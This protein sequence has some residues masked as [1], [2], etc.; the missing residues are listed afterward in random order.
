MWHLCQKCM[1]YAEAIYSDKMSCE[2]FLCWN[3]G[4]NNEC[5]LLFYVWHVYSNRWFTLLLLSHHWSLNRH[6]M[7]KWWLFFDDSSLCF[8]VFYILLYLLCLDW[9]AQFIKQQKTE[10]SS[11]SQNKRKK[12][13]EKRQQHPFIIYAGLTNHIHL[14][15][16]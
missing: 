7:I 13:D 14:K 16:T 9:L 8:F 12:K 4:T 3:I 5:L 6:I 1:K 10:M 2:W 15:A 11:E